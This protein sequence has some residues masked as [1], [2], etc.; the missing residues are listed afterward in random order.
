MRAERRFCFA[1][2]ESYMAVSTDE[3]NI[4]TIGL[5]ARRLHRDPNTLYRWRK[6]GGIPSRSADAI[7]IHLNTHPAIIWP[8]FHQETP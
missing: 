1:R 6:A 2:L 4:G 5:M 7:A 3:P 8:D